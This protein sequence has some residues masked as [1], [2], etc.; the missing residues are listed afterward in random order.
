M[1]AKDLKSV[2]IAAVAA[3]ALMALMALASPVFAA[4]QLVADGGFGG[5]PETNEHDLRMLQPFSICPAFE[6][7][8]DFQRAME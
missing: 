7:A 1:P 2:A 8:N 4:S 3:A 5:V 6:N